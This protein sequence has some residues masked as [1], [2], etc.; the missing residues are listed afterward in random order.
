MAARPTVCYE[1]YRSSTIGECLQDAIDDMVKEGLMPSRMQS[2]IMS[3]FDKS[4]TYALANKT[5]SKAT[6]KGHL[7][8]YRHV[9]DVWTFIL[10]DAS[11][12]MDHVSVEM[13]SLKIV[14][15]DG[16]ATA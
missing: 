7:H 5:K 11:F 10:E 13:E 12:K 4:I 9:D 2:V 16:K 15:C 8:T 1:L 3:E 6:F 14:A